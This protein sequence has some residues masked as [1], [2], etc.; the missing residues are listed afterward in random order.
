LGTN[1]IFRGKMGYDQF[2]EIALIT[3][4]EIFLTNNS[5]YDKKFFYRNHIKLN[6][7]EKHTW[8]IN[9]TEPVDLYAEWIIVK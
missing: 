1:E 9:L 7:L 6:F 5:I 4:I 3:V 8:S 2:G